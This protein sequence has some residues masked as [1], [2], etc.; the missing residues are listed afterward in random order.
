MFTEKKKKKEGK[1]GNRKQK[2]EKKI[3]IYLCQE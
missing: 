3:K 2:I 1:K